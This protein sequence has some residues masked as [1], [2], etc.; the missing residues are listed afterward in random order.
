MYQ[1]LYQF[2]KEKIK[3][4]SGY[5]IAGADVPRFHP[6][7]LPID[8]PSEPI[9][10]C[11]PNA[12]CDFNFSPTPNNNPK[13]MFHTPKA[14]QYSLS[15]SD[16]GVILTIWVKTLYEL[17]Y[18]L[19]SPAAA[20]ERLNQH[21]T[22]MGQDPIQYETFTAE[23]GLRSLESSPTAAVATFQTLPV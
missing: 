16:H 12:S 10:R 18:H 7:V 21:L 17:C 8:R 3:D 22:K 20:W 4:N 19:P 5:N 6:L 2:P 9:A 11:D 14:I 23:V 13:S 1:D 15:L